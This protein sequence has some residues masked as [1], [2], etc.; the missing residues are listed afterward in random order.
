[1]SRKN[2]KLTDFIHQG[3]TESRKK[4]VDGNEPKKGETL[5]KSND[6]TKESQSSSTVCDCYHEI[7]K[8]YEQ[9]I[10]ELNISPP[11]C[12]HCIEYLCNEVSAGSAPTYNSSLRI[13]IEEIH[14]SGVCIDNIQFIHVR[15]FFEFRKKQKRSKSTITRDKA[16]INGAISRFEAEYKKFPE[17]SW[18]ISQN[19]NTKDYSINSG[20]ERDP[21]T[22]EE[23]EKL[24]VVLDDFRNQLMVLVSMETGPRA[25]ATCLIKVSD[26]DLEKREIELKNTKIGGEYKLPLTE[27]LSIL[28]EHWIKK[29]R[30]SYVFDE[31]NPYLFPSR[32]GG[33]LSENAYRKIVH[34]AAK[35]AGIQEKMTRIPVTETQKEAMN[36]SKDYRIKWKVDVH[37]LRHTFSRLLKSSKVSK[38]ARKY[39]LDH[40][41]DV[42]DNYGIDKAAC[43]K[44]IRN[45]FEGVDTTHI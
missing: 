26:V 13:F 2:K 39:A 45:K 20:F 5:E 44:E 31:A 16:A 32:A 43:I 14:Q 38:E 3:N 21:L 33:K 12:G 34:F 29:V 4:I 37:T 9:E 19:I 1:M 35:E 10:E 8:K 23:I 36:M 30:S 27:N 15:D 42:T 22:D 41:T 18:K 11:K 28:L 6:C 24:V 7:N 40:S 17:V 25:E